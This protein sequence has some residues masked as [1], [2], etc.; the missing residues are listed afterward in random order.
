MPGTLPGVGPRAPIGPG[1]DVGGVGLLHAHE[2]DHVERGE[3]LEKQ[4]MKRRE[5]RPRLPSLPG[6]P[7]A[8]P[9]GHPDVDVAD[10]VGR[11]DGLDPQ[12]HAG[13]GRR[14][15]EVGPVEPGGRAA[16]GHDPG[17]EPERDRA[18]AGPLGP[19]DTC[20]VGAADLTKHERSGG[21]PQRPAAFRPGRERRDV[22]RVVQVEG[23]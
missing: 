21:V 7:A 8:L 20:R 9:V 18:R 10:R 1:H 19:V 6:E 17:V 4:R 13:I 2:A 16:R 3:P 12:G 15:L 5:G 23:T 14:H 11:V 22:A